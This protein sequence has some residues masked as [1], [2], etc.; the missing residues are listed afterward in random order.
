MREHADD[1]EQANDMGADYDM[2]YASE[3]TIPEQSLWNAVICRAFID[4]QH[5]SRSA[6][7]WLL[8]GSEDFI[9]VCSLAGVSPFS[10]RKAAQRLIKISKINLIH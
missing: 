6:R 5:G 7:E 4:A 2:A 9:T 10:V 3:K 1:D 8:F